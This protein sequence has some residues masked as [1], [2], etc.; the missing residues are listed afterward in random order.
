MALSVD[1][2]ELERRWRERW[3]ENQP[4][5]P[6]GRSVAPSSVD[7]ESVDDDSVDQDSVDPVSVDQDSVD[8]GFFE[9]LAIR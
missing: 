1:L 7:D 3:S 2:L 5:S 6:V 9:R 8:Q 4:T